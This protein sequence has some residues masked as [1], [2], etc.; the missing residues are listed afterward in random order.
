MTMPVLGSSKRP[1]RAAMPSLKPCHT[2][3]GS[4]PS[5]QLRRIDLFRAVV[6]VAI[7][8]KLREGLRCYKVSFPLAQPLSLHDCL[9]KAPKVTQGRLHLACRIEPRGL[10]RVR[11]PV[12][13]DHLEIVGYTLLPAAQ[14]ECAVSKGILMA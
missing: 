5:P 7:V 3:Y 13:G 1:Y 2:E 6:S 8:G 12:G 9:Y 14:T 11:R 4:Q 10:E